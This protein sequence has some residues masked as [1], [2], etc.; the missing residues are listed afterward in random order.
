MQ[1][2]QTISG[3]QTSQNFKSVMSLVERSMEGGYF[4]IWGEVMINTLGY[5]G[6]TERT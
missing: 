3:P 1:F 4:D 5:I 6:A 2:F